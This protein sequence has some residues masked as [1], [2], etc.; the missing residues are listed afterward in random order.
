MR[1][2]NQP[3]PSV[4]P[5]EWPRVV[6]HTPDGDIVWEPF[7]RP[8]DAPE[9]PDSEDTPPMPRAPVRIEEQTR[10]AAAAGCG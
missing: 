3:Q 8:Q 10:P 5:R 4:K 6:P 1:H 2:A 9:E 7:D